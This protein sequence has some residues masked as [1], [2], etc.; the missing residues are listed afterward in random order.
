LNHDKTAEKAAA[1]LPLAPAAFAG[2]VLL[3]LTRY[4]PFMPQ[5]IF[6][7]GIILALIGLVSLI[8]PLRFLFFN[9]KSPPPFAAACYR[10][11]P[12]FGRCR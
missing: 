8:K 3:W 1:F 7:I 11:A 2:A 5:P 10:P 6:L 4:A 9:Q 12:C